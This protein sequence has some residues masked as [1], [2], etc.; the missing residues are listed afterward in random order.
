MATVFSPPLLFLRM[1]GGLRAGEQSSWKFG[2]CVSLA[3]LTGV[4]GGA[5][6][7]RVVLVLALGWDLVPPAGPCNACGAGL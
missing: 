4:A 2:A 5:E 7:M 6:G 1:L 3:S